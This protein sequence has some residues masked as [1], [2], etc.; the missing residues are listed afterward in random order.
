MGSGGIGADVGTTGTGIPGG[1]GTGSG[2]TG[3]P[4]RGADCLSGRVG[5]QGEGGPSSDLDFYVI[6][7]G[8]TRQRRHWV[9]PE[10]I[11]YEIFINLVA[12]VRRYFAREAQRRR[13]SAA[14]MIA[15]GEGLLCRDANLLATLR[16]EARSVLEQGP[17]P[18]PAAECLLWA[19]EF[20]YAVHQRWQPKGK[21]LLH[22]LEQWDP[23]AAARS[24]PLSPNK[25]GIAR[26]PACTEQVGRPGVVYF[27][28]SQAFRKG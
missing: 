23:T 8:P 3:R 26:R 10:G 22:D 11:L 18:L 19:V 13:P 2:R 4:P 21:H 24:R 16:Q 15:T 12:Q 5:D 7:S 20:H 9:S 6:Q 28:L 1:G 14:H 17:P 27:R 25:P